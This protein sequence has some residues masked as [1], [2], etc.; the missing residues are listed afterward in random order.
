MMPRILLVEDDP[1]TAAFLATAAGALPAIVDTVATRAAA[2]AQTANIAYAVWLVDAH[3]PDGDGAGLLTELRGQG[4]ATPAIAHTASHD[5]RVHQGLHDAG[6]DAVLVKP[7]EGAALRAALARVLAARRSARIAEA[8]PRGELA[9]GA[10][11]GAEREDEEPLP[12]WDDVAALRALNGQLAHVDALRQ[13]FLAELPA[14]HALVAAAARE[15][16][17][18]AMRA[19]LHRLQASCGFVGAAR[20]GRAVRT[21]EDAP[22]SDAALGGFDAAAQELLPP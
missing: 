20:L 2:C 12:A 3:L 14:A 6:F 9:A 22:D 10:P 18:A 5:A 17:H 1:T 7:L 19:T 11:A 15:G 21:L 16:D 13:L 8:G 4:L